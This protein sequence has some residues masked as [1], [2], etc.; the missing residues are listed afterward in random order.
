M[1]A[2][3]HSHTCYS[4][5]SITRPMTWARRAK[6][7][8]LDAIALTD[9]ETTQG[10]KEAKA[11]CSKQGV[12]FIPG[13][14]FRV[15]ENGRA[16]LEVLG[17]FLTEEPKRRDAEA[18]DEVHEQGGLVVVPHPFD[19]R[20]NRLHNQPLDKYASLID[21]AE[22]F[23]ARVLNARYDKEALDWSRKNK[24]FETGCGDAHIP[25]EVGLGYTLAPC[26]PDLDELLKA[27]LKSA[28]RGEGRKS[29][30][31]YYLPSI[32]R[33]RTGIPLMV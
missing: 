4:K 12:L 22:T 14:E 32:L 1:K 10:W 16:V 24:K 29:N 20:W 26:A 33:K 25:Q 15:R 27:L 9:H 7:A 17:L 6:L 13:I 18:L 19:R 5:D 8:G 23:N 31:L 11:E 30:M 2:D 3:L 21:G 28:T